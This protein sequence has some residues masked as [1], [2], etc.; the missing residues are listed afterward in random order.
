MQAEHVRALVE[1][2][3]EHGPLVGEPFE[4][5]TD[6]YRSQAWF[7]R[8]AP[9]REMPRIIAASS[10]IA[11]GACMPI[12]TALLVRDQEG[13]LRGFANACRHRG[14]R[15]IDKPCAAKAFVCPYHGWTYGLDGAL[16]HVPHPEAFAGAEANRD[17]RALPISEHHGLVWFGAD[18]EQHIAPIADDLAA[19]RAET[20][21][22]FRSSVTRRRCNWKFLVEAFLDGYHIRTL[23][24]DSIYRFFVDSASLAESAGNHIRAISARRDGNVTPSLF[25]FPATTIVEHPDFT[26]ILT[27]HARSAELTDLEHV[28]L[29]P[30]ERS[31]EIE[32]WQKSWDLIDGMVFQREDQWVCEEIQLGIESGTEQL[33][34]GKLEHAVRWFHDALGVCTSR[35]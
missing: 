13:V 26:S 8:E 21:V 29:V 7:D 25:V 16:L 2:L 14:A 34:F 30:A 1:R 11:R 24:R 12:G 5:T 19:L 18:A 23:H 27:P 35:K 32:H 9:L 33:L 3:R 4:L 17:L 6:R 28:M 10:Q 20:M 15:L 31:T 22:V